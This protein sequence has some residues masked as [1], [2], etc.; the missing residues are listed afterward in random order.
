MDTAMNFPLQYANANTSVVVDVRGADNKKAYGFDKCKALPND[1]KDDNADNYKVFATA[2]YLDEIDW[3][4][5]V[6]PSS[7]DLA[8]CA[9]EDDGV[10]QQL[11]PDL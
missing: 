5:G 2:A 6:K 4:T 1:K 8:A 9:G 3:S 10:H 7:S 11:W